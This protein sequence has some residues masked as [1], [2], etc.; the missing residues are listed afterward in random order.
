MKTRRAGIG[1]PRCTASLTLAAKEGRPSSIGTGAF[2][3]GS[4]RRKAVFNRSFADLHPTG[5]C[6]N[7][8]R[9]ADTTSAK[10][11]QYLATCGVR[12]GKGYPHPHP[13]N[14]HFKPTAL[15]GLP[16]A[17]AAR[18]DPPANGL[19]TQTTGTSNQTFRPRLWLAARCGRCQSTNGGP[20]TPTPCESP[21]S[22]QEFYRSVQQALFKMHQAVKTA[23]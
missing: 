23:I 10:G 8:D 3:L 7:A 16:A 4:R 18:K 1:S 14:R 20:A 13:A 17:S 15:A 5:W 12:G 11:F 9:A 22:L 21:R 6:A 2:I 19:T